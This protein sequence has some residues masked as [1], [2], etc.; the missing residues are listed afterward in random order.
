VPELGTI[1]ARAFAIRLATYANVCSDFAN[2]FC[3]LHESADAVTVIFADLS[4][5]TSVATGL[6]PGTYTVYPNPATVVPQTSGALANTAVVA[7]TE[8]TLTDSTCTPT[9]TVASGTLE[10]DAVSDSATVITGKIDLTFGT[11]DSGTDTFTSGAGT[12]KGSFTAPVCSQTISDATLCAIAA[13]AGPTCTGTPTC[14]S[15]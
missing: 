4:E 2:P 9:V 14:S 7:F 13:T 1:Y 3:T 8:S 11:Y 5:T 12:L 15:T 10:I 6:A